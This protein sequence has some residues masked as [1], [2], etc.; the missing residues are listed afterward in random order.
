MDC[1][2]T[3]IKFIGQPS[4][5]LHN[6]LVVLPL[7]LSLDVS[8]VWFNQLS[9]KLY[10]WWSCDAFLFLLHYLA[11]VW[12]LVMLLGSLG[13]GV[14]S[15]IDYLSITTYIDLVLAHQVLFKKV[16]VSIIFN[17]FLVTCPSPWHW[18]GA[19]IK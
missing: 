13:Y 16:L 11:F 7:E 4:T 1:H 19:H 10:L 12:W 18:H 5:P 8:F 14:R 2:Q 9:Q 6:F 15:W 3:K 17:P